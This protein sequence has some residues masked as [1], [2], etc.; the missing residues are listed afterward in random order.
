MPSQ[1]HLMDLSNP[2]S[3][4]MLNQRTPLSI[5]VRSLPNNLIYCFV[6]GKNCCIHQWLGSPELGWPSSRLMLD[7]DL[8]KSLKGNATVAPEFA[9]AKGAT[10]RH[11]ALRTSLPRKHSRPTSDWTSPFGPGSR[12]RIGTRTVNVEIRTWH[13]FS[14]TWT[15]LHESGSH[16][17]SFFG[18]QSAY[19]N[20][21]QLYWQ[22]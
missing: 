5:N 15:S 22:N 4:E 7:Q 20:N 21:P 2:S 3:P 14:H 17:P 19:D 11:N 10:S 13:I 16:L 1:K 8:L 9:M 12:V 18:S 6:S